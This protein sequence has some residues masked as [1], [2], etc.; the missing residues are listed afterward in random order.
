MNQVDRPPTLTSAT[1][2]S[3]RDAILRGH[4]APGSPLHEEELCNSLGV[5]RGTVREAL[6]MLS[7]ETL[8]EVFPHRGAFVAELSYN[9][10][11]ELYTLRALLEPYAV[12]IALENHAYTEQDLSE[13]ALLVRDLGERERAGDILGEVSTDTEFHRRICASSRHSLLLEVLGRLQALT[14]LFVL[15]TKLYHS[16]RVSNETVHRDIVEALASGSPSRG[17]Q[18]LRQHIEQSGTWLLRR[19]EEVT[20]EATAPSRKVSGS[21]EAEGTFQ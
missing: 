6:R 20:C 8:V 12:R 10:A 7:E 9:K 11:K 14:A 15:N 1:A 3:L 18:A 21:H 4:L 17:E 13:L 19:M 2:T 5:S 16:D